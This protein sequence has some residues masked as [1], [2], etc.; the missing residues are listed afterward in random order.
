ML[1][2]PNWHQVGSPDCT[3]RNTRWTGSS[4]VHVRSLWRVIWPALVR[5]LG[6][7]CCS[8]NRREFSFILRLFRSSPLALLASSSGVSRLVQWSGE[9][10]H[11]PGAGLCSAPRTTGPHVPSR[12]SPQCPSASQPMRRERVPPWALR[13]PRV[14]IVILVGCNVDPSLASVRKLLEE[15]VGL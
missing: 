13:R 2:S 1:L 15:F 5:W 12:R 3:L 4:P 6:W 9:P 10:G 14:V 8:C 7:R 11:V